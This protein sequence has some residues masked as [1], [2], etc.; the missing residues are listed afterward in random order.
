MSHPSRRTRTSSEPG[1]SSASSSSRGTVSS[2]TPAA[3]VVRCRGL[4]RSHVETLL[5]VTGE[6]AKSEWMLSRSPG[7]GLRGGEEDGT[8][9]TVTT[10]NPTQTPH[11]PQRGNGDQDEDVP[12]Q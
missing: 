10:R 4:T 12:D 6:C 9:R 11:T 8:G 2:D 3:G 1:S 7:A 5:V